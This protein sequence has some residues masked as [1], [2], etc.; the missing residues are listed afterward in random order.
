[1]GGIGGALGFGGNAAGTNFFPGGLTLVGERGPELVALPR[2]SQIHN[3]ES[4]SRMMG[5]GGISV[6]VNANMSN[7][8]DAEAWAYRIAQII[9]KRQRGF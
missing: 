9:Q 2:G 5:G 8:I 7:D 3:S 4:T 6:T 1:M